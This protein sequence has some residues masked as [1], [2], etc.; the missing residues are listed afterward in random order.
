M[1]D[2]C[3][4]TGCIALLLYSLLRRAVPDL[5]VR[6][7]DICPQAVQLARENARYNASRG[8]LGPSPSPSPSPSS[9]SSSP[10]QVQPPPRQSLAFSQADIFS[11]ALLEDLATPPWQQQQDR[12]RRRPWDV[13]VCN[14][15]Y[16]SH[17]G[18]AHQTARCVRNHEPKL[19][20]VP[21]VTYDSGGGGGSGG[22][23]T[24]A[25]AY[26]PEDV[27]YARLLDIGARLRPGVML[28]EVG[29]LEQALRVV[30]M[31]LGHKGLSGAGAEVRAEVWRD[32]PD[33]TPEEG[34][35]TLATVCGGS[36]QVQVRGSG[37]GRS[38]L[39]QC[40]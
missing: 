9:P 20:Q 30:D 18:F 39:I 12:H 21:M 29:D 7:I 22:S 19:A 4:G 35:E 23:G 15:P 6:G 5:H 24:T 16:V 25:A 17:W 26:E 40:S 8:L 11:D 31:A 34:E 32:W 14:P 10:S 38:V 27:F 36:R 3:T 33:A 13:M 37:H 2:L 1:L 28:F